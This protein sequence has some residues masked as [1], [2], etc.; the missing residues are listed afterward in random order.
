LIERQLPTVSSPILLETAFL[1]ATAFDRAVYDN[2]YVALAVHSKAQLI[3][4]DESWPTLSPP[5]FQ[6]DG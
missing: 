5:I 2:L 3:T 1:I 4:A 6:S